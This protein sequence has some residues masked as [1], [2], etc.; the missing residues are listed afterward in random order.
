MSQKKKTTKRRVSKKSTSSKKLENL[1]QTNGK[2]YDQ[3]TDQIRKLEEILEVKTTN[4]FGTSSAKVFEENLSSMNLSEMQEIA[5]R[6][7]IF[8]SGSQ[9]MLKNKLRK[10]FKNHY[11]DQ[12]QVIIDKG[13]PIELDPSNPKHKEVIDYLN[14]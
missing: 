14:S 5:V 3:D 6:A 13:S 1:N 7:G 9:A 2:V 10:S 12:L 4:P 11:P 8:P